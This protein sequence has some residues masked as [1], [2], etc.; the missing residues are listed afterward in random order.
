MAAVAAPGNTAA[1][2]MFRVYRSLDGSF[3]SLRLF[4][5]YFHYFDTFLVLRFDRFVSYIFSTFQEKSRCNIEKILI[6]CSILQGQGWYRTKILSTGETDRQK[7]NPVSPLTES[8]YISL[9]KNEKKIS[10]S[11]ISFRFNKTER[12]N[13]FQWFLCIFI[14]ISFPFFE[15]FLN[16]VVFNKIKQTTSPSNQLYVYL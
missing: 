8:F 10:F 12:I 3:K 9:Q 15:P 1:P 2:S 4:V 7:N 11:S 6:S 14:L 13:H 16:N 5:R